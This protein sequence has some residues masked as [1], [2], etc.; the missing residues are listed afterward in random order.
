M[1]IEVKAN[2]NCASSEEFV[3]KELERP[4]KIRGISVS[5]GGTEVDC[6]AVGV[7]GEGRFVEAYATKITDSGAGVAYMIYGGDWGIRLRPGTYS[8]EPWALDNKRQ[9]GEPFK[10]YGNKEDIIW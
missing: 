7:D 4:K 5:I 8:K 3:Y 2:P 10:I 6:D 1:H 9:W